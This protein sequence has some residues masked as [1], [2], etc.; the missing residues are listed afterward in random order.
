MQELAIGAH[1]SLFHGSGYDLAGLRD[2]HPGDRLSTIDWPQSS[3]TNFSPLVT[4][5]G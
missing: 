2:W 1:P 3:L 5:G 4:R